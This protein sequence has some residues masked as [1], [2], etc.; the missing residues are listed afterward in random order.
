MQIKALSEGG[1]YLVRG[2]DLIEK[3]VCFKEDSDCEFERRNYRVVIGLASPDRN[4][5]SG[6]FNLK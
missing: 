6:C 4:I 5:F 3:C 1:I 2:F